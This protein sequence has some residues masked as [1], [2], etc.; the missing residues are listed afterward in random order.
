MGR[1]GRLAFLGTGSFGVPLLERVA[2]AADD[3]LIVSQPDRPAG[4]KLQPRP[5]PVAAWG[6]EHG[7]RV[8]TP[9][10]LRSDEGRRLLRAFAPDG[11]LLASYGQLVPA[12]LLELAPRPPLNV[13]PSLLP[14]HR[15]A[16]PVAAAILAGDRVTGVTLMVMTPELDAGPIVAQWELPLEGRE[17]A[18]E[19]ERRLAELAAEKVPPELDRWVVGALEPR[20]QDPAA[21]TMSRPFTRADGWIDW[22]RRATEIDRQVRAL[23]PWPGAWTTLDGRRLHVRAAHPVAGVDDVPIGALLPGEQPRVACGEGALALDVVQPEGRPAMPG[24]AWR[25]GVPRD[26]VLLG[27]VAP[28]GR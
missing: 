20:P 21:A 10:R 22:R 13:H 2:A 14:R 15:G 1:L 27:A 3:L 12:D 23:Q 11:L 7:L 6:R 24:D 28:P 19:L 16:A 26:H 18:L 9:V 25:R 17:T 8:E 5:S 4:R